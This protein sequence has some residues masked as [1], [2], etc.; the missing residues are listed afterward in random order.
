MFIVVPNVPSE[1]KMTLNSFLKIV[2]EKMKTL[3]QNRN[4]KHWV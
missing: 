3:S 4:M 1:N 2:V